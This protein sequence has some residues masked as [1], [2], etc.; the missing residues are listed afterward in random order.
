MTKVFVGNLSFK[1]KD[2]E[3]AAE[4]SAAGKVKTANIITRGP[5]SLGYGFVELETEEEAQKAVEL[6]N[7]KNIDGREINVELAKPRDENKSVEKRRPL[8]RRRTRPPRGRGGSYPVRRRQYR[9]SQGGGRGR[10]GRRGGPPRNK[11]NDSRTPSKTTLFVANLPFSVD[12]NGLLEVFKESNPVKAHVVKNR[13]GKSKG[14]GFV[15]FGNELEQKNAL[16]IFDRKILEGRELIVKVALTEMETK[17]A[18]GGN[19]SDQKESET[20]KDAPKAEE[21]VEGGEKKESA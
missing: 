13:S 17:K 16:G 9:P 6:M 21:K 2:S 7:R 15:E 3:L 12:D 20:N 8:S 5:R 14:F 18:D 19:D 11:Q 10:G 4:F 1:T